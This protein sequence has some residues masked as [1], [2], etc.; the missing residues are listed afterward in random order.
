FFAAQR[1]YPQDVW[2]GRAYA[3]LAALLTVIWLVLEARRLFRGA[4]MSDAPIGLVEG[5][6]YGLLAL[7]IACGVAAAARTAKNDAPWA[8]DLTRA[9]RPVTWASVIFAASMLLVL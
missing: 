4:L 8:Q 9:V 1:T 5:A 7:A 6:T 2:L 3:A